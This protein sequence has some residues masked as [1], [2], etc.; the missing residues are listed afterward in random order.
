MTQADLIIKLGELDADIKRQQ[1]ALEEEAAKLE[2]LK[3][4]R[5]EL[6]RNCTH[7]DGLGFSLWTGI[8]CSLC[9]EVDH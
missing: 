9:G 4:R 8:M 5:R 3:A 6:E 2:G 7:K 1:I